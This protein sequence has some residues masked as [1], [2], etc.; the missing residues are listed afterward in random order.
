MFKKI[1]IICMFIG[2]AACKS[3]IDNKPAATVE[4]PAATAQPEV[5]ADGPKAA[6]GD[7]KKADPSAEKAP[8]DAGKKVALVADQSSF[9]FVGAKV[10]GDHTGSFKEFTGNGWIGEKGLEKIDLEVT[11]A[12]VES[13]NP[14]LTGHLKS[15]D[16]FD[17]ASHPKARFVSKTIAAD[18]DKFK[19]AGDMTIRGITKTISFP[20]TITDDGTNLKA[21]TEFTLKRFDFEIAYK[22]KADNLIKDDVLMK[23]NLTFPKS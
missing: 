19:I 10:T 4:E 15:P 21:A 11:T 20:A 23:I 17:V 14:K 18:G 6:D 7:A 1:A 3:E 13:D 2:L 8:A 5:K 22:G 9:G 16:F 12:S